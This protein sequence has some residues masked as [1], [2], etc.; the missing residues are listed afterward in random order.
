MTPRGMQDVDDIAWAELFDD[1]RGIAPAGGA[2]TVSEARRRWAAGRTLSLLP[3]HAAGAI[4]PWSVVARP[5]RGYVVNGYDAEGRRTRSVRWEQ[6]GEVVRRVAGEAPFLSTEG[7]VDRA[8]AVWTVSW[9]AH[10]DGTMRFEIIAPIV[11]DDEVHVLPG[12]PEAI[13]VRPAPDVVRLA[14]LVDAAST[15]A[16]AGADAGDPRAA[17]RRYVRDAA[18]AAVRHPTEA[19]GGFLDGGA[20][21]LT[22][23][24]IVASVQRVREG[25]APTAPLTVLRRGAAVILP[26]SAQGSRRERWRSVE[27][28]GAAL[29]D[30]L[31]RAYEYRAGAPAILELAAASA[32]ASAGARDV[33]R[34]ALIAAGATRASAWRLDAEAA[35][36]L[37]AAGDP[38]AGTATRA[39]HVVPAEWTSPRAGASA[40]SQVDVGWAWAD[41]VA[42]PGASAPTHGRGDA[43][44][45][46]SRDT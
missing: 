4:L 3:A 45:V 25:G 35:V 12:G 22:S 20:V 15:E 32:D 11:A 9:R 18:G 19:A 2:L 10:A 43:D 40:P 29:A 42:Q 8:A 28:Q 34:D 24:Q 38:A 6:D 26:L 30:D 36:V 41:V 21:P 46:T 16:A 13:A 44:G 39:L 17:A 14:D 7:G 23:R 33:Y 27:E 1:R 31:R 37:V 5:G